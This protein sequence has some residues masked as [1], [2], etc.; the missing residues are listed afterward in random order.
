LRRLG[1]PRISVE[2]RFLFAFA[3]DLQ[4]SLWRWMSSDKCDQYSE[5][6]RLLSFQP[7]QNNNNSRN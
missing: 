3:S 6:A 4:L 5:Q 1:C 2:S 7:L